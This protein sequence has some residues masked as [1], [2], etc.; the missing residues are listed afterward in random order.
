MD[1]AVLVSSNFRTSSAFNPFHSSSSGLR[2]LVYN[3]FVG[4]TGVEFCTSSLRL[5]AHGRFQLG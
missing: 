3:L 2:D 5:L 4:L 1:S